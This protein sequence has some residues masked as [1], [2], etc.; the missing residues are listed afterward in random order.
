MQNHTYNDR[1]HEQRWDATMPRKKQHTAPDFGQRLTALRKAAGYTQVE[2]ADELGITQRMISHYEG[3]IE[4]PPSAILPS[5]AKAL[6]VTTD[7]LLGLRPVKKARK[8]DT[9]LER[10]LQ[11]IQKLDARPRKQIMQLIDTFI[12]AERLKQKLN[13]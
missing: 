12:E 3:R 9:R 5:L 2:L 6:G 13:A 7:E 11:Q 1:H 8:R 4:H 10:R